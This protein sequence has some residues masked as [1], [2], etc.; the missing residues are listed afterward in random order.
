MKLF[1]SRLF[2]VP[3]LHPGPVLGP[4][5]LDKKSVFLKTKVAEFLNLSEQKIC[6][7]TREPC[8]EAKGLGILAQLG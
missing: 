7:V 2:C 1:L 8:G 5:N 3:L 4:E 6:T